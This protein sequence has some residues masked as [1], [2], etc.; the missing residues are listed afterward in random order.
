MAKHWISALGLLLRR[1]VLNYVPMFD[2]DAVL[3]SDDVC[4]DPC[5]WQS[6]ARETAVHDDIVV[7][8]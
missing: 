7:F 8:D 4:H 2:E 6:V 3:N 1:L 5:G